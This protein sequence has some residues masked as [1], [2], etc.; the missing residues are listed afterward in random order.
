MVEVPQGRWTLPGIYV[1][2]AAGVTFFVKD[3]KG[4]NVALLVNDIIQLVMVICVFIF[5]TF[6]QKVKEDGAGDDAAG[7][8]SDCLRQFEDYWELL[9][10]VWIA[11]YL[12]YTV[13]EHC[14]AKEDAKGR[15][16]QRFMWHVVP[17]AIHLFMGAMLGSSSG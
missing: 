8:S 12:Y 15:L 3:V 10:F 11:F 5:V 14:T 9:W 2:V 17:N 1:L 7:K 4:W 6:F 16:F 13:R